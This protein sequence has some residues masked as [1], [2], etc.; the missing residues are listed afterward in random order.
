MKWKW[1]ETIDLEQSAEDCYGPPL[2]GRLRMAG[3]KRSPFEH[4]EV[5]RG[6]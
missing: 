6:L 3:L 4:N 1:D 2:T 5:V